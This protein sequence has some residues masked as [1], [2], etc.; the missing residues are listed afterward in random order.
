VFEEGSARLTPTKTGTSPR[1]F[2]FS[3]KKI[4]IV[5]TPLLTAAYWGSLVCVEQ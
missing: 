2:F 4:V 5:I 1:P 3:Q